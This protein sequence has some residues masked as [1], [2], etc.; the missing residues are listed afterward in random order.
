MNNIISKLE[1]YYNNERIL[2]KLNSSNE[3]TNYLKDELALTAPE[4]NVF[5]Y[6]LY[7]YIHDGT[8][9][10]LR[11]IYEDTEMSLKDYLKIVKIVLDLEKKGYII[12]DIDDKK[13]RLMNPDIEIDEM[14][15]RRIVFKDDPLSKCDYKD[16]HSIIDTINE[17]IV[18]KEDKKI[19]LK[20]FLQLMKKIFQN[21]DSKL[22]VSQIVKKYKNREVI[23]FFYLL[24][25]MFDPWNDEIEF[26]DFADFM[27]MSLKNKVA[28]VSDIISGKIA[29]FNDKI[30]EIYKGNREMLN[31][32]T[33]IEIEINSRV[34]SKILGRKKIKRPRLES[35]LLSYISSDKINEF[36]ELFFS[37]SFEKELGKIIS[38][39]SEDRFNKIKNELKSNGFSEG[40]VLLFYGEPG[41][42]KTA[43]AFKIAVNT[44][45]DILKVDFSQ[46]QNKWVGESEKNMK[47]VFD[48]YRN[49]LEDSKL[50]PILLFNEADSLISKRV[51]VNDSVDQMNNTLQNILL[52]ELENFNGIFIAT[53]NLIENI[54]PAFDRR[55]LYKLK[56]EKPDK[57]IRKKIWISKL[58]D[59]SE[60]I[61][62]KL[63]EYTLTGGQIDNIAKKYL[64][65]KILENRELEFS[66]LI[67]YVKEELSFRDACKKTIG[68][69]NK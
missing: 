5:G 44:G 24:T 45:R 69:G 36:Q 16:I 11:D 53:T 37:S 18:L 4:A 43:S 38:F 46:V 8:S 64:I 65:N 49:A 40:A 19:S 10:A 52:E 17:L 14:I 1:K 32:S 57:E 58:P 34:M 59:L 22:Y 66:E 25:K 12:T 33:D 13:S 29:I 3:I 39:L 6:I 27:E 67:N 47:R 2:F 41:T 42:G 56:F 23:L 68:F 60:N 63:S 21:I 51:S 35:N 55:F 9:V 62:E 26:S 31:I 7:R 28:F 30:L 48:E 15:F 50:E 61:I 20:Y 54:D